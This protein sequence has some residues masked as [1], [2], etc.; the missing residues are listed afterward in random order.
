[1]FKIFYLILFFALTEVQSNDRIVFNNDI[2]KLMQGIVKESESLYYKDL[3]S[4]N[5][6]KLRLIVERLNDENETR[7]NKLANYE[8]DYGYEI[9]KSIANFNNKQ[10]TGNHIDGAGHFKMVLDQGCGA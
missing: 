3:E 9:K 6:G 10:L 7:W 5:G 8:V 1:M 2:D 4:N